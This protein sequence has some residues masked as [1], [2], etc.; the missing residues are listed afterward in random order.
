MERNEAQSPPAIKWLSRARLS[1][2]IG[3]VFLFFSVPLVFYPWVTTFVMA[4]ETVAQLLLLVIAALWAIWVAGKGGRFSLKTPLTIP[5]IVLAGTILLSLINTEDFFASSLGL[6]LWGSYILVFFIAISTVDSSRWTKILLG[7]ALSAGLLAAV[8][9][10]FQFYG[11]DFP[12]WMKLSGRSRLFSTFG[13]TTYVAGYLSGCLPMA[14]IWF[15]S[16]RGRASKSLAG[17]V[18]LVLYTA[19]FMSGTRAAWASLVIAAVFI[20]V[21]LLFGFGRAVFKRNRSWLIG[22]ALLL[23]AITVVYSTPNLLNWE[24]ETV[25]QTVIGRL[26]SSLDPTEFIELPNFQGRLLIWLST[27]E[28]AKRHPIIGS[29]I[30]TLGINYPEGQS[31]VLAQVRYRHLIPYADYSINAH[32]DLVH[33]SAEIGILGLLAAAWVIATFYFR[34]LVS[35]KQANPKDRFLLIGFM[36]G[37]LAILGHSIFSFPFH[38]IPNGLLFWLFLALSW[39]TIR[40]SKVQGPRPDA[41]E[42]SIESRESRVQDL[43]P[44]TQEPISRNQELRTTNQQPRTKNQHQIFRWGIVAVVIVVVVFLGMARVR[45]FQADMYLKQGKMLI[46]AGLGDDPRA[47]E[48]LEIATKLEPHY[49]K[50][51]AY[52]GM[53]YAEARRYDEAIEAFKRAE[54]NWIEVDHYEC[55]G[56]AYKNAGWLEEAREVF[57]E[58]ITI[59]PNRPNAYTNLGDLYRIQ[60]Q[61]QLLAVSREL[62]ESTLDRA[63]FYYEQARVFNG[64]KT[65]PA[66]AH[67][68]YNLRLR[69]TS[70]VPETQPPTFF[71]SRGSEPIVDFLEPVARP[72]KPILFKLFFHARDRAV[73][74]GTIDILT[75]ADEII[76]TLPLIGNGPVLSAFLEKG[77]ASGDYLAVANITYDE[78]SVNRVFE[79]TVAEELLEIAEFSATKA[80]LEESVV[81]HLTIQNNGTA[82]ALIVG[83]A[84]ISD[85]AGKEVGEIRFP[86]T[87]VP[88]AQEKKVALDWDQTLQPGLY[89]ASVRLVSAGSGDTVSGDSSRMPVA[90]AETFFI[91]PRF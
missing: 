22:L 29:G 15:V 61:E 53:A 40:R 41:E 49:G 82:P 68:Y 38:V 14:F 76:E 24:G 74:G 48:A 84:K 83:T 91:V 30:G 9:L 7:A 47:I 85:G 42:S 3:L 21:L 28:V 52:L 58:G 51:Y 79:F 71:F 69:M 36:G 34:G 66:L 50:A 65:P 1:I 39:V 63:F 46:E 26:P 13:W 37:A 12:F 89:K 86:S 5:I 10:I 33:M 43:E 2:L 70:P 32:N 35:L 87:Y 62:A 72:D 67:D 23:L 18:V 11:I 6:A 77:P 16:S 73:S 78:E 8:Y 57:E 4:K 59:F 64:V 44:K 17:F 80:S 20:L 25:E 60:A 19:L 45:L 55:L 27:I 75:D 81:I 56:A 54:P 88:S 31:A 90:N